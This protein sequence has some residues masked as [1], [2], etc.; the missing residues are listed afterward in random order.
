LDHAED[1]A[2]RDLDVARH[3]L[4]GAHTRLHRLDEDLHEALA[5]RPE[6][7]VARRPRL[8]REPRAEVVRKRREETRVRPYEAEQAH[9]GTC[10]RRRDPLGEL[11]RRRDRRAEQL[12]EDRFLAREPVEERWLT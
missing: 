12:L 9:R 10:T 6:A 1:P 3:E 11:E 5:L 4:A 2:R 7:V 8:G